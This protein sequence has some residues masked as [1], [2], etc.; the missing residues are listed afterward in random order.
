VTEDRGRNIQAG[1]VTLDTSDWERTPPAVKEAFAQSL[2][3]CDGL[4]QVALRFRTIER[5]KLFTAFAR[6]RPRLERSVVFV[7]DTPIPRHF[8]IAS[9]LQRQGWSVVLL[10]R[11]PL[12]SDQ[13]RFFS[14]ALQYL[15]REECLVLACLFSPV[16]YHVFSSWNFEVAELFM[17]AR[18]GKIVFESYD[19]LGGALQPVIERSNTQIPVEKFCFESADAVCSRNLQVRYAR[20]TLGYKLPKRVLFFPDYCWNLNEQLCTRLP[21]RTDGV[22]LVYVGGCGSVYFNAERQKA[23]PNSKVCI[24]EITSRGLHYH[25]YPFIPNGDAV[26]TAHPEYAELARRNPMFHLHSCLSPAE[27]LREISQYHMG[28]FV[29]AR[30]SLVEGDSFYRPEYFKLFTANKVFDYLDAGL[31]ALVG[32]GRLIDWLMDRTGAVE[33]SYLDSLPQAL[34]VLAN[35]KRLALL[36]TNADAARVM[37][38]VERQALRLTKFYQVVGSQAAR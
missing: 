15:D 18:P 27:V 4:T 2:T 30:G 19:V 9:G 34:D 31:P 26:E 25:I 17:V 32:A 21:K 28:V 13:R 22:H 16:V 3:R 12:P 10:H 8:K 7:V 37:Y 6:M 36:A 11:G 29:S 1:T 35:P 23:G 38:G 33:L 24:E 5:L 14:E 20:R